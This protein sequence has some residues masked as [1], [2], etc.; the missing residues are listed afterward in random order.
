MSDPDYDDRCD[1]EQR[2]ASVNADV[3]QREANISRPR[4]RDYMTSYDV[5]FGVYDDGDEDAGL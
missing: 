2:E 5:P 3:E 4:S 1:D